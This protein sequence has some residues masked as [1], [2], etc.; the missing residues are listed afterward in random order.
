MNQMAIIK[1]QLHR[2]NQEK[3][4]RKVRKICKSLPSKFGVHSLNKETLTKK[5]FNLRVKLML[6]SIARQENFF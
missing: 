5:E 3:E 6:G 2:Q 1:L 4:K